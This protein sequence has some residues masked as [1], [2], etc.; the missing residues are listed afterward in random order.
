MEMFSF[1]EIL[2][3]V[4]MVLGGQKGYEVYKRK[5]YKNGTRRDRRNGGGNSFSD[6][7]KDF[8]R[9]C[10]DIH[11]KEITLLRKNDR[12]ELVSELKDFIRHDGESTRTA[13]RAQ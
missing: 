7:D 5:Q 1:A 4:V 13:V 2:T 9:E 10:F 8:V 11:T 6:S 12:L 3:A